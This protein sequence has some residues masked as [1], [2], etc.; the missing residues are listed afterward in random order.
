MDAQSL[1]NKKELSLIEIPLIEIPTDR[2]LTQDDLPT[3][4]QLEALFRKYG[5]DAL[6]CYAWRNAL[7]ALP[8]LAL[9]PLSAIWPGNVVKHCF[10]V[11][12]VNILLQYSYLKK[13]SRIDFFAN[14]AATKAIYA[15]EEAAAYTAGAADKA[16]SAAVRASTY[17]AYVA[18]RAAV[19]AASYAAEAAGEAAKAIKHEYVK[20]FYFQA[21]KD[22][23]LLL[24]GESPQQ[25]CSEGVWLEN[26]RSE[27]AKLKGTIQFKLAEPLAQF[28]RLKVE[29][30]QSLE[31]IGLGFL[32]G[33]LKQIFVGEL[34]T[35]ER[36]QLYVDSLNYSEDILNDANK[37][38]A[39]F[40]GA[41]TE[42]NPAL[43][44]LLVGPGGA[45]KSSL[46]KL[47]TKRE[48]SDSGAATI[49]IDTDHIDLTR[50]SKAG[51]KIP[52][53]NMDISLW[54][55]GGQSVFY[56]LHR[57]FM[58]RENCVYVLV[59]D[60]R[61][62]QAPD[63]WLGQISEHTRETNIRQEYSH[64]QDR[65]KVLIVTNAY[66]QIHREQN[67]AYLRR[68]F[69]TELDIVAF[70]TLNCI[71]ADDEEG[72][73]NQ[74]VEQLLVTSVKSQ[75]RI[76]SSTRKA[77]DKLQSKFKQQD[78]VETEQLTYLFGLDS[79]SNEWHMERS[80]LEN[81]GFI[82]P[83]G[84]DT[85]CFKPAW[86]TS[87]AYEAIN[88]SELIKKGGIISHSKM[89]SKVLK[90]ESE[91]E[92]IIQFLLAQKVAHGFKQQGRNYLFFPDAASAQE[93]AVVKEMLQQAEQV[94]GVVASVT[95]EY[96]LSTFPMGFKSHLAL[97][98]L[99]QGFVALDV[100]T[101]LEHNKSNIWRDGLLAK[102]SDNVQLLVFY[103]LG[104][105]KLELKWFYPTETIQLETPEDS[106]DT[107]TTPVA[108][109]ILAEPLKTIHMAFKKA[110]NDQADVIPILIDNYK[111]LD[112]QQRAAIFSEI[113]EYKKME[114]ED[115][116]KVIH[117]GQYFEQVDGNVNQQN[118]ASNGGTVNT[119]QGD[120]HV[121]VGENAEIGGIHSSENSRHNQTSKH[122]KQGLPKWAQWFIG[123]ATVVG[124][125]FAGAQLFF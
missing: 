111:R 37:L 102:F 113:K 1:I 80:A 78:F 41:A 26:T 66:D 87:T 85:Y 107:H 3:E 8:L 84:D 100:R 92:R 96:Q 31:G 44:V 9:K 101:E 16:A 122:N 86:I 64:S 56:N 91:P 38:A 48:V 81:L 34:L 121:A 83:S 33:D 43:R 65:A 22:F 106:E 45:G 20:A 25:L 51:A 11:Q 28:Y 35:E 89:R 39:A 76:M 6:L 105:Q 97:D 117:T 47:L 63:D 125:I 71:Q 118:N 5:K 10:A 24:T 70:C 12:R 110:L 13:W 73:F 55:F 90:K 52:T 119:T 124:A 21:I 93:P 68:I 2:E 23:N 17:A 69:G 114:R 59:V 95:I 58:R 98:L 82:V 79:D 19:V 99:H 62:E 112:E 104:K 116:N 108:E 115:V 36:F 57:S 40:T 74:F 109:L 54:D 32:V 61:H 27:G 42:A 18:A 88:H 14:D 94:G 75:R 103:H 7:R 49:S 30:F 15:A 67:Q 60:S 29:F 72:K 123:G 77:V 120:G 50:H 53:E 46:F 4:S